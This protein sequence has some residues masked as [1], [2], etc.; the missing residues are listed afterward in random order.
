MALAEGGGSHLSPAGQTHPT[1]QPFTPQTLVAPFSQPDNWPQTPTPLQHA[2]SP[3]T[4]TASILLHD[5]D[6][7]AAA[8]SGELLHNDNQTPQFPLPTDEPPEITIKQPGPS[9]SPTSAC[10]SS[11]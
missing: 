1:Q 10:Q 9:H 5:D 11:H 8:G 2:D 7:D 4:D 6:D 3:P